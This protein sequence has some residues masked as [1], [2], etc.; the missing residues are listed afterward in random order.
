MTRVDQAL[1]KRRLLDLSVTFF[2]FLL[3]LY[4][5]RWRMVFCEYSSR[6]KI[7]LLYLHNIS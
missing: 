3:N 2:L 1:R 4:R 5:W 6:P 7:N